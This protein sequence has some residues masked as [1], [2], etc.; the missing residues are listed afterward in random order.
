MVTRLV[1]GRA[2]RSAAACA[3]ERRRAPASKLGLWQLGLFMSPSSVCAATR[4][5][6]GAD[7]DERAVV[8]L[9]PRRQRLEPRRP[10]SAASRSLPAV[11]VAGRLLRVAG[12]AGARVERAVRADRVGVLPGE[13]RTAPCARRRRSGTRA[14]SSPR[15]GTT[16]SRRGSG[17]C[18]RRS[19][20][21]VPADVMHAP[22]SGLPSAPTAVSGDQRPSGWSPAAARG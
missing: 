22:L 15:A 2:V 4:A 14:S 20:T 16:S 12:E 7:R 10:P 17:R 19:R 11:D 3:R 21:P 5:A 8:A 1:D 18:R 13:S 9:L 6:A